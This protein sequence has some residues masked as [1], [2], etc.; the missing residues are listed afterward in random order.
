MT[1]IE[2]K[3]ANV[4]TKK[5]LVARSTNSNLQPSAKRQGNFEQVAAGVCPHDGDELLEPIRT[6]GVGFKVDCSKCGH[7][8]YINKKIRTCG[9]LTC[10]G[11]KRRSVERANAKRNVRSIATNSGGPL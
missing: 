1:V 9:C 5:A 7:T 4:G 10:K 3:E 8:W 6:K 11:T 2:I